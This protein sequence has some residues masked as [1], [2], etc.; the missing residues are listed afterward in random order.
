MATAKHTALTLLLT[1][2]VLMHSDTDKFIDDLSCN[3]S[4][5]IF[6]VLGNNYLDLAENLFGHQNKL[7]TASS[8]SSLA[9]EQ[10]SLM[11]KRSKGLRPSG[12]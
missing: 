10:S 5:C 9:H 7:P 2:V 3:N 4:R 11:R 6:M 8:T 12:L 1:M